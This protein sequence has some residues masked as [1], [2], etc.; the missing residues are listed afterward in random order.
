MTDLA[1]LTK[2]RKELE[3]RV[4]EDSAFRV[5]DI[6]KRNEKPQYHFRVTGGHIEW[7]Q[8]GKKFYAG[9]KCCPVYAKTFEPRRGELFRTTEPLDWL[10]LVRPAR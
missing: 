10:V 6:V 8:F 7:D 3:A 5:G 9:I 2:L 1:P 4:L